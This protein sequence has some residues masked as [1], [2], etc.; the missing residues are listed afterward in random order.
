[1]T[2]NGY[3]GWSSAERYAMSFTYK[4][5]QPGYTGRGEGGVFTSTWYWGMQ[6]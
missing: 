2:I 1:M 6:T 5:P 3:G 4:W